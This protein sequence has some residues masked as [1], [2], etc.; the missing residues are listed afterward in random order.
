MDAG[1]GIAN[2]PDTLNSTSVGTGKARFTKTDYH[3]ATVKKPMDY[4]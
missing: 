1:V 3:T 4:L 2:M